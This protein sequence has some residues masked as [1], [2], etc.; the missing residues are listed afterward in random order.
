M[1]IVVAVNVLLLCQE[2][3]KDKKVPTCDTVR[4]ILMGQVC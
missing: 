3:K 2:A 4:K 1:L